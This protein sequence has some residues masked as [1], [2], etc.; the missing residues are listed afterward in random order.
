MPAIEMWLFVS[1]NLSQSA[2]AI[3]LYKGKQI[4]K[5][6]NSRKSAKLKLSFVFWKGKKKKSPVNKQNCFSSPYPPLSLDNFPL[7]GKYW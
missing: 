4:N 3:K 7:S 5:Y 6:I 1:F 2:T